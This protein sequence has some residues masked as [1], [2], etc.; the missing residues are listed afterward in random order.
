MVK[1]S[2]S[3]VEWRNDVINAVHPAGFALFGEISS[4]TA[5]NAQI[6]IASTSPDLAAAREF[7]TPDLF[8][9]FKVVFSAK[10]GRRLG[11]TDQDTLNSNPELGIE[12]DESLN[13]NRD[14]TMNHSIVLDAYTVANRFSS[15]YAGHGV[16][17][18]NAEN[19][20]FA[21]SFQQRV[22]SPTT[23]RGHDGYNETRDSTS[24]FIVTGETVS[25]YRIQDWS[26]V[27]VSD[28]ATYPKKRHNITPPTEI[29]LTI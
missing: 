3:I 18:E 29:T 21:E 10:I 20:K 5:V 22:S 4:T 9:T 13:G 7:I 25:G 23:F 17:L 19:Y 12:L 11:T 27:T 28:I 1:S 15:S 26:D 14:V 24:Y 8:S 6:K 16:M 2:T